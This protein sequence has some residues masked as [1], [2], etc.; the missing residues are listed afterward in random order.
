ML[1]I[2]GGRRCF[3]RRKSPKQ[4]PGC[5]EGHVPLGL[6]ALC[7]QPIDMLDSGGHLGKQPGLALPRV[8]RDEGHGRPLA[9][10]RIR[11]ETQDR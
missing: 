7:T 8:S 3:E 6:E 5:G 10:P 2:E 9:L 4:L 1:R 11:G